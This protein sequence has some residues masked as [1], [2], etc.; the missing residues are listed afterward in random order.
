MRY[1]PHFLF[2]TGVALSA[3]VV[4]ARANF[5]DA[6]AAFELGDYQTAY[7]EFLKLA[8][9]GDSNAETALGVLYDDGHGVP[10]DQRVAVMWY[11]KAAE[12]GNPQAQLNLGIHYEQAQGVEQDYAVALGWYS[13]AAEQGYAAAEVALGTMYYRGRG[14]AQDKKQA[15]AWFKRAAD[16]GNASAQQNLA[17]AFYFGDGAEINYA[18]ALKLYQQAAAQ[19]YGDSQYNLG[20]MYEKGQGVPKDAAR[21]YFWWLLASARE[22]P[23]AARNRDRIEKLLTP[24]QRTEAQTAARQWKPTLA[25]AN[26]SNLET[27]PGRAVSRS[28]KSEPDVTGTALRISATHYVTNFHLV[29]GCQRLRV[30]GSQSAERQAADQRNDLALLSVPASSG[31]TAIIRIGRLHLGEQ[32]TAVGFPLLG[33]PSSTLSVTPGKIASLSGLQGDT[34]FL[35]I[36]AAVQLASSGAIF[37]AS[38]NVLG[39]AEDKPNTAG[40]APA[41]G[42]VSQNVSFALTSSALQGF[43]DA[44]GIDFETAGLGVAMTSAQVAA[45]AKDVVALLECWQ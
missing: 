23:D 21:A 22:V 34:R 18:E 6:Q 7:A 36:T 27:K 13:K 41:S 20:V 9:T 42:D 30:N 45:G 44:Y 32:V 26:R 38:G 14:V 10:K 19:G 17:N 5:A 16:Q 29:R 4:P 28:Q 25:Q 40:Q 24:A 35:Q 11:R 37:D 3:L 33:I 43:L 15:N 12:K 31:A 39:L 8:Q 2:A 1:F